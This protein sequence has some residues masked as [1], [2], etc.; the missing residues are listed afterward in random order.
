MRQ[1]LKKFLGEMLKAKMLCPDLLRSYD[2]FLQ[3]IDILENI[4][5]EQLTI[6]TAKL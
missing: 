3:L 4:I 1:S 6:T 5:M 2:S